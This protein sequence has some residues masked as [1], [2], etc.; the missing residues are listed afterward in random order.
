MA[1]LEAN[2]IR[3]TG[4]DWSSKLRDVSMD[5]KLWI[6]ITSWQGDQDRALRWVQLQIKLFSNR[7]PERA[8]LSHIIS[9]IAFIEMANPQNTGALVK[10][11]PNDIGLPGC[12]AA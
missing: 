7:Q 1:L 8:G 6:K 11:R 2:N 9:S 3:L 4:M 10:N 5:M 12:S